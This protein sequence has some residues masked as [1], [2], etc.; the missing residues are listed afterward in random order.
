MTPGRGMSSQII[1]RTMEPLFQPPKKKIVAFRFGRR[2]D[3]HPQKTKAQSP[4]LDAGSVFGPQ[5]GGADFTL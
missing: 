1:H 3:T 5:F 4:I 2:G